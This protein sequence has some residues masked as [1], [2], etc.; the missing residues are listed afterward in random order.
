MSGYETA[1]KPQKRGDARK[2]GQGTG[3]NGRIKEPGEW[4]GA[5]DGLPGREGG[6]GTEDHAKGA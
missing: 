4:S 5:A 1:R 3:E 2:H 6:T